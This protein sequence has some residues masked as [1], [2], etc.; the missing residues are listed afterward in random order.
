MNKVDHLRAPFGVRAQDVHHALF[1][2][3]RRVA[4]GDVTKA[5]E[6]R[7][8]ELG[9][10][11]VRVG[12]MVSQQHLQVGRPVQTKRCIHVVQDRVLVVDGI[13]VTS[14]KATETPSAE[15]CVG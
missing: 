2:V 12:E 3:A 13:S 15:M 5:K 14:A 4:N 1:P 7:V 10:F 11:A 6:E 9:A 8:H